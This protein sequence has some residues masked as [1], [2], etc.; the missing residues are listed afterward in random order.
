MFFAE[1]AGLCFSEQLSAV[2]DPDGNY[3]KDS[4]KMIFGGPDAVCP[5]SCCLGIM[6][7]V[8]IP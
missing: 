6:P 7:A 1:K 3:P 2:G 5:G 4:G 8:D